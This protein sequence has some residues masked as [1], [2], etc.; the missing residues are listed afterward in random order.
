M[1]RHA[2]GSFLDVLSG[3]VSTVQHYID[4]RG[5]IQG[6]GCQMFCSVISGIFVVRVRAE[7]VCERTENPVNIAASAGRFLEDGL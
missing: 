7:I 6:S 3:F 2:G 4:S 5:S 1:K